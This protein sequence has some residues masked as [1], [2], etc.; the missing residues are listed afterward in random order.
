MRIARLR[1]LL[2]LFVV[3]SAAL[4]AQAPVVPAP[5]PGA[6]TV[7]AASPNDLRQWDRTIDGMVRGRELIV[8]SSRADPDIESRQH[9]SLAQYY[10]G[11]PV[12]GGTLTRQTAQGL[13]VSI[14][15]TVYEGISID[16]TPALSPDQVVLALADVSGGR[17]VGDVPAL[18]IFPTVDGRYRLAYRATMSDAKTYIVDAA[19]GSVLWTIDEFKTQTQ[20]QVGVGTGVLGDTKKIS[21][22]RAGTG[23][24]T[25]DQLRPAPI[26]TFD[27]HGSEVAMNRLTQPPGATV[28]SD[29]AVDTDNT[30]ADPP[31]V[32]TH[33][34]S[35]WTEDY[36]FRRLGWTGI[37]NRGG[38]ITSVVHSGLVDNAQFRPPPFGAD[39][40]GMF[41]FGRT[42]AGVPV[43]TLD[44][45]GHEMMHGV[46]NASL[47]QRTGMGLLDA[48]VVD[49]AGP[50]S[51]TSGGSSFACDTTVVVFT[52][53]TRFPM[54]CDG[55]R[56]ILLSNHPGAVNEAFSDV[57]GMAVEFFYQPVGAGP[58]RADYK[59]GEDVAGFGPLRAADA[60]ASLVATASSQGPI[61]Y[62]DHASRIF[63]YLAAIS[64]GTRT[65]P[66]A[67]TLLPWLLQG[68]QLVTLPGSDTG[69]VH[70]NSTVLSH[71]F[72]LAIEGGRNAT[73]GLTVQ[74]VGP[75]NRIQIEKA[76]FRAMNVN[77]P[78]VPTMQ[79]A[80][81]ATVQAAVDL[82]GATSAPAVAIRQAMQ[83]V[84]LMN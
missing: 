59:M 84:G 40:R 6:V 36:F 24:R 67:I 79:I 37:D 69:G 13:T 76:F 31:V 60:P 64:Q 50:T 18:L 56:Y 2:C 21:T 70:L 10:Q 42:Q 48:L 34:H 51:M 81:Q 45:V 7:Y 55:G 20:S 8:M 35:G 52:D 4:V 14:L 5:Q 72:Y 49:H 15:G 12:F 26:R 38:Q 62:P 27:T 73:S 83:A 57:F 82:Y 28:D 53:G 71:A 23:F 58:L 32:D 3:A 11:V 77:M 44:V 75:A 80:A 30:W 19:S 16:T 54:F 33:V 22:T 63:S 78:N 74:G 1:V 47:T 39:G 9:E 41:V 68:D 29:F 65:N 25:Q 17:L 66:I 46:T 43:T 61:A